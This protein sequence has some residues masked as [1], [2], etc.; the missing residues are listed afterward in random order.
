MCSENL[1]VPNGG[2]GN[3]ENQEDIVMKELDNSI[4]SADEIDI[5]EVEAIPD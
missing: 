5:I 3:L 2:H 4:E 1:L